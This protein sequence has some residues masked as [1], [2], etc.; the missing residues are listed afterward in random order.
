MMRL[1]WHGGEKRKALKSF[2]GELAKVP[3]AVTLRVKKAYLGRIAVS[4]LSQRC[5]ARIS[6]RWRPSMAR[7][8]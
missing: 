7:Q 3:L 5:W 2:P 6:V 1:L 4:C 8:E